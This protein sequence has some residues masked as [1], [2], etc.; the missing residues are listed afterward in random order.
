[1]AEAV[2]LARD[3]PDG[4]ST[5]MSDPLADMLNKQVVLDTGTHVFYLGTLVE[6]DDRV[7]VLKDADMHDARD[8]H[9]NKEAYIAEACR[10]GVSANRR[11]V[12]VMRSAVWSISPMEDVVTG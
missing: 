10:E 11:K 9:A 8:G 5:T 7:F 2:C 12:V 1:M 6:Y 3:G 4:H